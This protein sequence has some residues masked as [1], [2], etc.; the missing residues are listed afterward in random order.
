MNLFKIIKIKIQEWKDN[1]WNPYCELCGSC[2]EEGCCSPISC[3]FK[4]MVEERPK[5]CDHGSGNAEILWFNYLLSDMYGEYTYKLKE[6]E[7]TT[8][9]YLE[10]TEKKWHELYDIA[11][12]ESIKRN[13]EYYEKCKK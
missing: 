6:K 9:E 8:E 4:C 5:K 3:L 12:A 1:K 13:K 2:G 7:I 11:F 10:I